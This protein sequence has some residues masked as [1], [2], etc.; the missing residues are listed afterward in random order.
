[1]WICAHHVLQPGGR[2]LAWPFRRVG[3]PKSRCTSEHLVPFQQVAP[4]NRRRPTPDRRANPRPATPL[5]NRT[6]PR[7]MVQN[8]EVD[9]SRVSGVPLAMDKRMSSKLTRPRTPVPV[10]TERS[11]EGPAGRSVLQTVSYAFVE[12]VA[13]DSSA[14]FDRGSTSHARYLSAV[15]WT[16]HR[17]VDLHGSCESLGSSY[18]GPCGLVPL[19]RSRLRSP[20]VGAVPGPVHPARR[21]GRQRPPHDATAVPLPPATPTRSGVAPP[22][23]LRLSPP[24]HT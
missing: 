22:G 21:C 6:A 20:V 12:E 19:G 8:R 18:G 23:I 14:L 24:R 2:C 17:P 16:P 10:R 13:V 1:M 9:G 11:L 15:E 4:E 7:G 5:L 3:T